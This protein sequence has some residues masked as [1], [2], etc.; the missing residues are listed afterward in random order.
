MKL[1]MNRSFI[2]SILALGFVLPLGMAGQALAQAAPP[3]FPDMTFFVTS[4]PGPDGANF[5]GL[6][7]ADKYCQA[8]AATA[9]AGGKTWHAYLSTQG[10]GAV[11]AR[12]RIGAGPWANTKGTVIAASVDEL[13]S[14]NKLNIESSLTET[15]RRIAG[16]GFINNQH[17]I[18]TGSGTDGR[19]LAADKDMTCGNWTKGGEGTAMVGHSDRLGLKDDDPS[20]SWN[21]SHP[22]RGCALPALVSTGGSGLLYCFATK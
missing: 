2:P 6:E 10:A 18:L 9:G 11:N 21:S 15:G 13:H 17:D 3:Q 16:A 22:T 4:K 7:G 8:A 12:D 19:A 20:R 1:K 14:G 5:G